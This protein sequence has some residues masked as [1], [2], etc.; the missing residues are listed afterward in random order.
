MKELIITE[1]KSENAVLVGLITPEQNE[2]Q[3]NE[4]LDELAFLTET[5]GIIPGKRFVQRLDMPN[6][7]TFV[8]TGKLQEIR[9]YVLDKDNEIGLVIFDDELSAKQIR[10]IEIELGIRIMDRT[11]LILD[12]FAMRAQTANAKVQVELAQLLI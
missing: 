8:G 3:V 7:V 11:S 6:S 4:Y 9:D 2:E 12:I 1:I 5:A 10:N